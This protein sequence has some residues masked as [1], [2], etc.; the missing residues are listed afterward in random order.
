MHES[1]PLLTTLVA[2]IL[3][4]FFFGM[5][6][7]RL[8]LPSI[9]GYLIAGIAIGPYTPGFTGSV[10][11]ASQLSDIGVILLMF[12][13][14][15]HFSIKDLMTVRRIAVPGAII[16]MLVGTLFGLA[17]GLLAGFTLAESLCFGFALSIAS[18]IVALRGYEN[19]GLLQSEAGKITLGWLIVEDIV[20]VVIIVLLPVLAPLLADGKSIDLHEL[21]LKFGL[22][23]IKIGV[24]ATLMIVFGRR[25]LPPLL[26]MIAKTKS[27]ELS[28]LGTLAIA[29]GFAYAAYAIF[30]A[31]FALGAF[32]AGFVLN[33]SEIGHKSAE[34]SIPLRDTFAV[35]F[36]VSAGMLFNPSI[37]VAEPLTVL[38]ALTVVA[39]GTVVAAF[40]LMR[41]F[42]LSAKTSILVSFSLAQIGEFSFIFAGLARYLEIMS[43]HL[44]DVILATALLSIAMNP[45]L[46]RFLEKSR[47]RSRAKA[48]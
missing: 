27:R 26:V 47:G 24:F 35:L 10:E 6:A 23:L 43:T 30:D 19:R 9:V 39:A 22:A 18:T 7:K 2:C 28:A 1:S 12:G 3:T 5:I 44:Y 8:N 48:A 20:A 38:M 16:Q 21:G 34:Q 33:E 29:L 45:F 31:S 25:L 46:F 4:A 40:V 37:L 41:L 11:I 17:G 13:V 42:G 32:L 15:L 14:G 36:F